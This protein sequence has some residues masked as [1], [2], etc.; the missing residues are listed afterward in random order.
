MAAAARALG[1]AADP[2][3]RVA[4]TPLAHAK[5]PLVAVAAIETLGRIQD[6]DRVDTLLSVAQNSERE[7]VKAALIALEGVREAR[8]LP[9]LGASLRHEAWDVRR[10]AADCLGRFGGETAAEVLRERLVVEDE[11][12]VR[13]AISRALAE[14][15]VPATVRRPATIAPPKAEP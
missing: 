7:V 11:P 14:I 10:L 1:D 5:I 4:L 2:R 12:M 15:E 6:P 3:A 13:E 8:V 9:C